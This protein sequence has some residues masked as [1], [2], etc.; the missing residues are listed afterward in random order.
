MDNPTNLEKLNSKVMQIIQDYNTFK[1]E[2][3]ELR[4]ELVTLKS[5]NQI[6]DSEIEKLREENVMKDLEI[7]DIVEKIE[8][9]LG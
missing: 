6:K 9:M 5:E 1:E 3:K 4:T 2:N 7:E 8:N